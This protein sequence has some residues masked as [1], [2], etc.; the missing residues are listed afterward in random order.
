LRSNIAPKVTVGLPVYNGEG[1]VARAIES[2]LDQ[3]LPSLEL[4]I[5]DNCSTDGTAAICES[6]A[7]R[8]S[9]IVY[10]RT[11]KNVGAA[12][13]YSRLAGLA[14]GQFFKWISHDDVMRSDF[15]ERCVPIAESS[16]DIIT[17]APALE[18]VDSAGA[19]V[20]VVRSYVHHSQW[21]R[22]RLKQYRDMMDELAYCETHGDGF[23]MIAYEYGLHRLDLLRKTRLVQPY[24][25]SD[26]VLAAELALWGQLVKLDLPL[27]SYTL[28]TSAS[29]TTANFVVWDPAAIQRM[30]APDRLARW[31]LQ[32]SVRQRHIEHLR[33]V[34]RAPLSPTQKLL[35]LEAASRPMRARLASRFR[36]TSDAPTGAESSLFGGPP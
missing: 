15:F 13:N 8:D 3:S 2:V 25:S 31:D 36:H 24:I 12:K 21:S 22:D 7:S 18:I 6:Y 1:L 23:M 5:S 16:S 9:R 10:T 30:L 34:W 19:P 32:L 28:S 29:S 11:E 14:R 4:V 27:A 33:A 35:A 17:V 26:Y 20:R